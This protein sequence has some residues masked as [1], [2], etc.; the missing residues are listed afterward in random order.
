[1]CSKCNHEIELHRQGKQRYCN[2]CHAAHMRATRP[3]MKDLSEEEKV[4]CR[5]RAMVR[6]RVSRGTMDKLPCLFC[7]NPDSEAH[8]HDYSKPLDVTWLCKEHHLTLHGAYKLI[9]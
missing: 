7:G 9:P 1:M 3:K 6:A 8:H 5:A 2:S 4:K